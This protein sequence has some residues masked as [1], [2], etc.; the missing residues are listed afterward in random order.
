[1]TKKPT[2]HHGA[3]ADSA[4]EK[5]LAATAPLVPF[6]EDRRRPTLHGSAPARAGR[7]TKPARNQI[8]FIRA[9]VSQIPLLRLVVRVTQPA[10]AAGVPT[11]GDHA[12]DVGV[13]SSLRGHLVNGALGLT[14][15]GLFL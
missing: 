4:T 15:G 8:G 10:G 9:P 11:A 2:P 5:R 7:E 1:M 12:N 13:R 6:Q 3:P 14:K